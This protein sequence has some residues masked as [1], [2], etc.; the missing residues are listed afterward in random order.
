TWTLVALAVTLLLYGIWPYRFFKK[1]GISGPR[2]LPFIGTLYGVR[3]KYG[4]VWLFEGRT[5]VL[6]VADP[7]MIKAILVKEC[8]TAFTNRRRAS[9]R[10]HSSEGRK[11]EAN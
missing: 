8:Y 2:P 1:V 6:M 9:V 5:P 3:K 4:D 7:E 10:N 11:V